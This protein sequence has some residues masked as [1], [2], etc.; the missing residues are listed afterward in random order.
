MMDGH[1]RSASSGDLINELTVENDFL[2]AQVQDLNAQIL[3]LKAKIAS[4]RTL[5]TLY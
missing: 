1:A 2:R 4:L 5:A 3:E